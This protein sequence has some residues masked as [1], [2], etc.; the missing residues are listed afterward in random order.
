[1]YDFLQQYM[2]RMQLEYHEA[3]RQKGV[4]IVSACGF[5]SIPD[6]LGLV[7]L[8]NQ[9]NGIDLLFQSSFKQVMYEL[10]DFAFLV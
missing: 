3:A 1:M 5:D 8:Q 2:D 4:Y 10:H 7:F 6:D 9:F